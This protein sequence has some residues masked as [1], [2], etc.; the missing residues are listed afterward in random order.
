MPLT[1]VTTDI[2]T[3]TLVMTTEFPVTRGDAGLWRW[4]A[5]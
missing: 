5:T 4:K 1:D 2:D 3:R